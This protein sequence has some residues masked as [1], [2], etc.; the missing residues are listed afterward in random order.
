MLVTANATDEPCTIEARRSWPVAAIRV[1]STP[2]NQII[3]ADPMKK[4]S[5]PM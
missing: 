1:R 5:P 3:S 2:P 4:T